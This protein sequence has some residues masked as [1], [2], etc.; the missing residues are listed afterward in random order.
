MCVR[1]CVCVCVCV[2]TEAVV[3]LGTDSNLSLWKYETSL[4]HFR[5]H[6]LPPLCVC[7]CACVCV[8]CVCVV[9][10]RVCV[11]C[12]C[13]VCVSLCACACVCVCVCV[14]VCV[15]VCVR[16][17]VYSSYLSCIFIRVPASPNK[18]WAGLTDR[19]GRVWERFGQ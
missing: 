14:S 1:M 7:A 4:C 3:I 9:C 11:V 19:A 17:C 8:W 6:A 12:V 5:S 16:L 15:C 13:V 18:A 10:V 2:F